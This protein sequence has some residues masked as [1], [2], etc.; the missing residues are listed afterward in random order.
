MSESRAMVVPRG[1]L[2]PLQLWT[3]EVLEDGSAIVCAAAFEGMRQHYVV[4]SVDLGKVNV[5]SAY[6]QAVV[7]HDDLATVRKL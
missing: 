2:L 6:C 5:R 1:E 7:E 3:V 4:R